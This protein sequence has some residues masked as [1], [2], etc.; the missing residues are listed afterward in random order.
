MDA[1]SYLSVLLSIII[2]LAITQVL[3]GYRALLLSRRRVKLFFPP[4]AW[5]VYILL[6]ATQ[7]WW[8]SFGLADHSDWEFATFV[9]IL[10]QTVFLYMLA[11]LVLP[12]IPPDQTIDLNRHYFREAT[13]FYVILLAMLL[14]SLSKGVL[15]DNKLPGGEEAIFHGV[16]VTLSVYALF[17]RRPW[18]HHVLAV[19][20]G[21][22][23]VSYVALLFA[24]L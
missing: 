5:S 10:L 2:G 13:P 22:L 4:L 7:S 9:V 11:G 17:D 21:L 14:T 16:F 18:I 15:L 3:Q 8:S 1:F 20:T 12:D 6:I 24:R 23:L 19:L